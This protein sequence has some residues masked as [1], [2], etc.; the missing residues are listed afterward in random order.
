ML[1]LSVGKA[2]II[3]SARNQPRVATS[4]KGKDFVSFTIFYTMNYMEDGE[5][6][7]KGLPL[8]MFIF[9]EKLVEPFMNSLDEE[10][11][12]YVSIMNA[13][14]TDFNVDKLDKADKDGTEY[15]YNAFSNFTY[16]VNDFQVIKEPKK[17]KVVTEEK[18]MHFNNSNDAIEDDD[19]PF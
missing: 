17:D 14:L 19:L 7:L 4:K 6:K 13:T 15:K 1:H 12:N 9:N 11:D 3:F 16:I 2:K 8:R 5:R 10:Q 18:S